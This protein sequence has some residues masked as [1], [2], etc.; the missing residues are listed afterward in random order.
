MV[1]ETQ[2]L[3]LRRMEERDLPA[4]RKILQDA[5]V[6]YAYEHAFSEEETVSWLNRQLE[7]YQQHGFGLWAV[8]L[9]ENGE[10]IG[11][12][13]LTM[14]NVPQ[15][16]VLEIG[17]LFQKAYWHRGYAA[18]AVVG[19]KRYAFDMLRADEV[20]SIIRDSNIA[21]QNVAKRN[22]MKERGRFV[23]HYYGV[24]MPHILFSI[25][26]EEENA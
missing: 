5:D 23:K 4:L 24:D 7:R 15:G 11:Q 12:C 20:F 14:Q 1:L 8:V 3:V 9:K 16:E 6:M 13:G 17:Y 22:G 21:S 2:R 26:R 10:M 19:C 25:R 18:E